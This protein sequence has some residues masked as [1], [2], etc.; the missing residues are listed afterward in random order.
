MQKIIFEN[1]DGSIGV[2]HPI[3]I[4]H[5]LL[6]LA[7]KDVPSGLPYWVVD[8]DV[9]PADRT[10]RDAWRIDHDALGEPHGYGHEASTFKGV[11]NAED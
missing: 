5:G 1:N 10:Y 9:L 3:V 8:A 11:L 4:E 7:K 6:A 2:I